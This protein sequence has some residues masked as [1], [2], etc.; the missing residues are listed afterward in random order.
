[1]SINYATTENLKATH[2]DTDRTVRL[3]VS[4]REQNFKLKILSCETN[5]I[6]RT[7][8][9]LS[10]CAIEKLQQWKCRHRSCRRNKFTSP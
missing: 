1:M 5:R 6:S 10:R 7:E 4:L 3:L 9:H 2:K 8:D